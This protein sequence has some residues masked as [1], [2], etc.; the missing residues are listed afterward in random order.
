[1]GNQ[2]WCRLHAGTLPGSAERGSNKKIISFSSFF[3]FPFSSLPFLLSVHPI[4]FI[5]S[6]PSR[7]FL[8][9]KLPSLS[10]VA[11]SLDRTI[12]SRETVRW[13]KPPEKQLGG[14]CLLRAREAYRWQRVDC[15]PELV[16]G[17]D[18][19]V[20]KV[21]DVLVGG[22]HALGIDHDFRVERSPNSSLRQHMLQHT[23][24]QNTQ[25][26]GDVILSRRWLQKGS[27][28]PTHHKIV[29]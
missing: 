28:L 10:F 7:A 13:N 12:H 29:Y 1:M 23:Q 18:K 20:G 26:D 15:G 16:L 19:R 6:P 9:R 22:N 17:V 3:S 14:N 8:R 25:S 27:P 4:P 2:V 21:V 24:C 11:R 5:S